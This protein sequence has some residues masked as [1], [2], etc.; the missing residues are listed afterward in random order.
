MATQRKYIKFSEICVNVYVRQQLSDERVRLFADFYTSSSAGSIP[1]IVVTTDNKLVDGRHRIA[2][3]KSLD[4]AGAVCDIV[5]CRD[6]FELTMAALRANVGGSKELTM[7]DIRQTIIT[8]LMQGNSMRKI[9]DQIPFPKEMSRKLVKAAHTMLIG[10]KTYA[11][12]VAVKREELTPEAASKTYGI[13]VKNIHRQ[14]AKAAAKENELSELSNVGSVKAVVT[15]KYYAMS[16]KMGNY[17]K[18]LAERYEHGDFSEEQI[19]EIMAHVQ[20]QA[21]NHVGA[22]SDWNDRFS[23]MLKTRRPL[24]SN[25]MPPKKLEVNEKRV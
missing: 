22:M 18:K 15:R 23:V 6:N 17:F 11:A 16:T 12:A 19:L 24:I 25:P 9:T 20:H 7:A 5:E 1:P 14:I 3:L 8:L 4:E 2:A 10:Q 21:R 13:P